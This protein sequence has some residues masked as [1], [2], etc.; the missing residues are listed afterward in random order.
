MVVVWVAVVVAVFVL[1]ANS[2]G[3]ATDCYHDHYCYH[4]SLLGDGDA[5]AGSRLG[6]GEND[7][8]GFSDVGTIVGASVVGLS[9]GDSLGL[10]E[11][12]FVGA[13]VGGF[14]GASVGALVGVFEGAVLGLAEGEIEG[15]TLGF[16]LGLAVGEAEGTVL[17]LVL[18]EAEGEALGILLGLGVASSLPSP[19]VV[20]GGVLGSGSS[21]S[22]ISGGIPKISSGS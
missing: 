21:S 2:E 12:T 15:E 1:E 20:V 10:A 6:E 13:F 5:V 16:T 19:P 9:E 3:I 14:V 17:G 18:G 8:T 7:D 4:Y 11:G 22:S